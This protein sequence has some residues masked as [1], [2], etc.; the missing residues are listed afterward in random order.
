MKPSLH[1]PGP[2]LRIAAEPLEFAG[3]LDNPIAAAIVEAVSDTSSRAILNSTVPSGKSIEEITTESGI[4]L[5][6]AYRRVH[7]LCAKG[8]LVT[9]RVVVTSRGKRCSIYRSALQ[10]AKIDI[11]FDRV[12]VVGVPNADIPDLASRLW[13]F[14]G[15][16]RS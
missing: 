12:R 9:E 14:A 4:P 7:E 15:Q 6:T 2:A 3:G 1:V 11:E 13:R 10:G 5:S 8:L 16:R